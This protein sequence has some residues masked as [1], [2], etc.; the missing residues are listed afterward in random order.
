MKTFY[1][2]IKREFWENR[3]S[4]F[5]APVI[6]AGVF[7]VFHVI[8]LAQAQ[9]TTHAISASS[10]N[11]IVDQMNNGHGDLVGLA[12]D[13]SMYGVTAM[14]YLVTGITLFF[15]CLG[16]LFDDRNDRS[17]LFWKS[18][19]IS[20]RDTVLSKVAS[21][22]VLA[23]VIATVVGILAGLLLL[24][25]TIIAAAFYGI[26]GW[27]LLGNTHPFRV[28]GLL[29]A[30]IPV[31]LV[32]ALPAVG[33]LMLCSAWARSKPFLWATVIPLG[34]GAMLYW[35]DVLGVINFGGW[36]WHNIVVRV[37][38]SIVPWSWFPKSFD[39]SIFKGLKTP[40]Q[41]TTV[42]HEM[43]NLGHIWAQLLKPEFWGG[44]LLGIAMIIAA[45][46]LRRWRTET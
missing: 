3:G 26:H 13:M 22:T 43:L 31:S 1:W 36:F 11:S 20:D 12:L 10:I 25:L 21:A 39:G 16:S 45:I 15:Y 2:L 41:I 46:W 32:W 28:M 38:I 40:D 37:F 14:V 8:G 44:A 6:T 33:W 5:W 30:S 27:T 18:L 9:F 23:P 4:F 17:Y 7:I 42:A 34:S 29:L 24:L 35:L 19:P